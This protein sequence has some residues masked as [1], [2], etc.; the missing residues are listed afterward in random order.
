MAKRSPRKPGG[1]DIT[2]M[3]V[4]IFQKVRDVKRGNPT[5]SRRI[6]GLEREIRERLQSI[7]REIARLDKKDRDLVTI[8]VINGLQR[9]AEEVLIE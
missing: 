3:A 4:S 7:K 8:L 6:D 2:G 5:V 9:T 1:V